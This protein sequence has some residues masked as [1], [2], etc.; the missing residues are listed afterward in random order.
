MKICYIFSNL[1]LSDITAEPKMA[2]RLAEFSFSHGHKIYVISNHRKESLENKN[3]IQYLLIKGLGDLKTYLYKY[4]KIIRYL[5]DIRPDIIHAQG[6]LII[7]YAW[8]LNLFIRKP[9]YF[10]LFESFDSFHGLQKKILLFCLSRVKKIFVISEYFKNQLVANGIKSNKITVSRIGL[11]RKFLEKYPDKK[12]LWDIFFFGDSSNERGFDI[13]YNLAE[14]MADVSF[15]ILIRWRKDSR[16][17]LKAIKKLKN[18]RLLSITQKQSLIQ[19]IN[20]SSIILLPFRKMG[21]RPPLSI[22]ESMALEKCVVTSDMAGNGE[23]IQNN[24]NGILLN[25]KSLE[26]DSHAIR[27]LLI[28]PKRINEM[29]K[30]AGITIRSLYS[31]K[32]YIKIIDAYA[33]AKN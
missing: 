31:D 26:L 19:M 33:T 11:D 22:I 2:H 16:K 5:A 28:N 7:I 17:E 6:G 4:A 29:G 8:M 12:Q 25:F 1:H 13:I 23:I 14:K 3:G 27:N 32:E 20:K 24:K 9:L 15:R 30:M 10:S 18:V 21:V